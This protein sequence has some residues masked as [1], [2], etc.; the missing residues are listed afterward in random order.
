MEDPEIIEYARQRVG[1][2]ISG[3]QQEDE[4][5]YSCLPLPQS[6]MTGL[7]RMYL[8]GVEDGSLHSDLREEVA[9]TVRRACRAK[10]AA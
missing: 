4:S 10:K 5:V 6:R 3:L 1:A 7:T 9:A 8:K 2:I